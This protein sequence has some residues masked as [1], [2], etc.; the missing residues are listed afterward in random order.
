M[1]DHERVLTPAIVA[2][3]SEVDAAILRDLRSRSLIDGFG[4]EGGNGRWKYSLADATAIWIGKHLIQR[5]MVDRQE[6]YLV[7]KLGADEVLSVLRG[8]DA[9]ENFLTVARLGFFEGDEFHETGGTV[10]KWNKIPDDL[11]YDV[12]LTV[13][14]KLTSSL[15]PEALKRAATDPEFVSNIGAR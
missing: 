11:P 14:W 13:D 12:Y 4:A 2:E 7:G 1:Y 10:K 15:A 5:G 9:K 6:A 3:I 8:N